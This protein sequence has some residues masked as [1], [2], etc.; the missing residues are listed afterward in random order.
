M[1]WTRTTTIAAALLTL[2]LAICCWLWWSSPTRGLPYR[3]AFDQQK[4]TEWTAFGGTWSVH[5]GIMR[6][7]SDQ[8]GAKLLTGSPHWRDYVVEAD[9][10]FL[11][12]GGDVGLI[13]R[14]GDEETGVD[15]YNGYYVGLRAF[16]DALVAGRAAFGWSEAL[17]VRGP[18]L[19]L[20][21][22]WFH[23]KI[24]A[25]GCN[26]VASAQ[27]LQTG[28]I[29]Y[30]AI[31]EAKCVALGRI[32]LRSLDTGGEWRNV[33]VRRALIS[34]ETA[35]MSQVHTVE[36]PLYPRSE[37]EYNNLIS[38]MRVPQ[39]AVIPDLHRTVTIES[40]RSVD[41][42]TPRPVNVRGV[43]TLLRP[44]LF[45]Q[46]AT[47]GAAVQV[48]ADAASR[49]NLGDEVEVQGSIDPEPDDRIATTT[50]KNAKVNL[51]WGRS[52]ASPVAIDA[53]EGTTA[54]VAGLLVEM[55]G[56]IVSE[57]EEAG[58]IIFD[59]ESGTQAFR[60]IV[61]RPGGGLHLPTLAPHS[62][63]RVRG[64][65]VPDERYTGRMTP[66]VLLLRSTDDI[67][68]VAGAPWWSARHLLQEMIFVLV[69]LILAQAYRGHMQR[70]RRAA[71]T[72]E[73]ERLA[74]ELHDTLAQT[75]AGLAFQ[76]HG[77]R[78]RLRLRERA[79]FD[80]VEQQLDA[81]SDFVRRTHQEASLSIAMLRS[82]SPEIGDLA[83]ALERSARELTAPG[84][85]TVRI[86][87][88]STSYDMPLRITD[89]LFHIAREALVN[90]ARHAK[91]EK[92]DITITFQRQGLSLE[93]VDDG[94]GFIPDPASQRLGLKGIQHRAAAIHA[95]VQLET[96]PGHGT[97]IKVSAPTSRRVWSMPG[98][99]ELR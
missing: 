36:E 18:G 92:I 30:I 62:I 10:R 72:G 70:R 88:D 66:F 3:S 20:P 37:A 80:M 60:A 95:T 19:I 84:V 51:L 83:T 61:D 65:C 4:A 8:R 39:L 98:K 21:L 99:R 47:G 56:E 69:L 68:Q 24:V 89:A 12:N 27:D 32:G 91:A 22:S 9:L 25:M 29:S 57:R 74:H 82:Q 96:T 42:A 85:A 55:R 31:S 87:G 71:I 1:K 78:N 81:A 11:G 77:I 6:N 64:V 44:E 43:V 52:P 54:D 16:D 93:V 17:P 33:S 40:L 67:D 73:R 94:V 2:A 34:D 49:L 26:I 46:D 41:R 53:L 14:S 79:P 5:D 76:L 75:F 38:A 23:L 35:L 45:V 7:S 15:A 63:V 59:L 28:Q 90:A 58:K 13:V 86:V 50:I 97:R 48:E